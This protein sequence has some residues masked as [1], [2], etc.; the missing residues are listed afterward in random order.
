M[1]APTA[2]ESAPEV[3]ETIGFDNASSEVPRRSLAR[4]RS[5]C[6]GSFAMWLTM[7]SASASGRPL[8]W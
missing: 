4:A 5:I 2:V 6:S 3:A 7:W 8:T 1:M